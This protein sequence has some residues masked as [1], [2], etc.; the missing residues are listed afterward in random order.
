ME[1]IIVLLIIL[2][3]FTYA[4]NYELE[5]TQPQEGLT[6]HSRYY[7]AYPGIPYIVPIGVF[8][9]TYPFRYE[10]TIAPSGMTIDNKGIITWNNPTVEGS[11]HQVEVLV[12]DIEGSTD[13]AAWTITVT[14]EGFVFVDARNG[15][16]GNPGTIDRPLRSM[17][18]IYQGTTQGY[19]DGRSPCTRAACCSYDDYFIYFREGTYGL[20]GYFENSGQQYQMEWRGQC[21]PHVWLA[22]P[23]EDVVID[24]D[25]LPGTNGAF[26]DTRDGDATDLFIHG[27]RFQDMLNHAFRG[28]GDRSVFFD[29]EFINGGPGIDGANSAFIMYAGTGPLLHDYPLIKDCVFDQAR[30]FAFIKTYGTYKLVVDGNSFS[31]PSGANEGLALKAF[32]RYVSVRGNLFTGDFSAGSISGNWADGQHFDISFNRILDANGA[33]SR[34]GRLYGGITINYHNTY[35]GPVNIYRNTIDGTVTVRFAE[36]GQG[37]FR[38]YNNVIIN[39]NADTDNPDGSL[40]TQYDV[41]DQTVIQIG[42][43][44]AANLVGSPADSII[45]LDGSLSQAYSSYRGTHGHET[46]ERSCAHFADADCDGLISHS[47][48]LAMITKWRED[49]I[50]LSSLMEAIR[51]WKG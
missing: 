47:E 14:T 1:R 25:L 12:T 5:I 27:I 3:A 51:I 30:D 44:T 22:F 28:G 10:V 34:S 39:D 9:G 32:D 11:P 35:N 15:A 43:G 6:T 40:I 41:N 20:E 50:G 2:S 45:G 21:K 23:G 7:K 13:T 19:V 4:A 37:P 42:S 17:L 16:P 46:A 48:M 24:H 38:L 36:S 18:D 29:C 31:G 8:G 26:I 33:F 49:T